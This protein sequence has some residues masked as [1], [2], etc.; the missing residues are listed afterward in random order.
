MKIPFLSRFFA[1]P[2]R[3]AVPADGSGGFLGAALEPVLKSSFFTWFCFDPVGSPEQKDRLSLTRYK[4]NGP[5]FHE[6][7]TLEVETDAQ[8][9]IRVLRLLVARSFIDH[10]AEGIFASDISNSF[11]A[12]AVPAFDRGLVETLAGEITSR[13]RTTRPLIRAAGGPTIGEG[14]KGPPSRGFEVFSGRADAWQK[15]TPYTV[16]RI[17]RQPDGFLK[18]EIA[19]A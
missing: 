17:E 15:A 3:P 8:G 5:K 19:E 16:L 18:M 6:L 13:A 9:I 11:L 1:P 2:P 10:P 12:A 4:P 7:V 14:A